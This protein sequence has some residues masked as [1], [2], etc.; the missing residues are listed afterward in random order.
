MLNFFVKFEIF[1][2]SLRDKKIIIIKKFYFLCYA[3]VTII[4]M[5]NFFFFLKVKLV[6]ALSLILDICS[7]T[8]YHNWSADVHH[9]KRKTKTYSMWE[10]H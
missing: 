4:V 6:R 3:L 8:Q 5:S 10:Y 7:L 2:S 1:S 9:L